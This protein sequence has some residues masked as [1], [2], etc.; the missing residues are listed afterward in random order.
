MVTEF[1]ID[2][3]VIY[4]NKLYRIVEAHG[5]NS[6]LIDPFVYGII[7]HY[8]DTTILRYIGMGGPIY[9]RGS[10][11]VKSKAMEVLYGKG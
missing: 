9:V 11:L 7:P 4:E 3:L 8:P 1:Q 2:D 10:L 6:Q 5:M